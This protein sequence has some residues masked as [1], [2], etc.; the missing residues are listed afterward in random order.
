MRDIAPDVA[1]FPHKDVAHAALSGYI[2]G[3]PVAHPTGW[4]SIQTMVGHL[5]G[6][7][8]CGKFAPF[9]RLG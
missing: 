9:A 5:D 4:L 7:Y 1:V 8:I 2:T 6:T 3:R